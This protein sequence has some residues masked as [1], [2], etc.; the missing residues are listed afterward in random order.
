MPHSSIDPD[1][2][3]AIMESVDRFCR[4][5]LAP[6]AQAIDDAAVFPMELYKEFASL[7]I[8]SLWV[9]EED[10]GS[11]VDLIGPL[12]ISER[13][14]RHNVAFAIS[15]SNC[16]DCIGPLV[17][18][19]SQAVKERYLDRILSGEIVP[20]FCLSEPAG[21]SDVAAMTTTA[22]REGT[23][24]VL[25]GRKMWITSAPVAGVFIAFAKT[26]PD[27]GHKGITAFVVPRDAPGLTVGPTERLLGLNSSPTA[28]V[29]FENV[30][31]SEDARLGEE[32]TGFRLAM[33]TMDEARVNIACCALGAAA[34][35]VG[36]AVQ[37]SRERKQFGKAI[38]DHQG[39]GFIVADLVTGLAGVRALVANAVQ[40]LQRG[41]GRQPGVYAAMA[42]QAATDFAMDAAVKAAQVL[43][44]YG[45][46]RSY[47]SS[48]L[49]R[50]CKALQ[51]FE[52]TNE[53]QKWIISRELAKSGLDIL[54][55]D[56]LLP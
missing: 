49:I 38:I 42:K 46:T 20:A 41:S 14:A 7:G 19:G 5:R 50:D 55:M 25:N 30:V 13:L 11:G 8:F 23:N 45:L 34:A 47:V 43:G 3:R 44:G 40:A 33:V 48:R 2:R 22:R 32:G 31:V 21:G 24:Y 35:A 6:A 53:I 39:L 54:E 27:A 4:E 28:E 15:I 17:A 1:I 29:S 36:E 51:I 37:Y 10:G 18:A 26:D 56:D 12:K 16:G 52:G 9:P